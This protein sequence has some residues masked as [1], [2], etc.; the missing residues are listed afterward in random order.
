M[1]SEL[2]QYLLDAYENRHSLSFSRKM[3]KDIAIQVD[4]QDD[5]DRIDEFCNI[6]CTVI[7]NN[8]FK[9][10]LL[11]NFPISHEMADL[12]EIYNGY[13]D[14]VHGMIGLKLDMGKIEVLIDLADKIRRTSFMGDTVQNK[15]WL[16]ISARTISSLYRFV[17]IMKEYKHSKSKKT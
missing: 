7:S 8:K 3:T 12:I 17:R 14:T 16:T 2:R 15:N 4:D 1:T 13:I 9:I 11:G 6:F 5:N 10:D